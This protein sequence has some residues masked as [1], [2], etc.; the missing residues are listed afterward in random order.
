[1]PDD[2]VD[3]LYIKLNTEEKQPGDLRIILKP[4]KQNWT[5]QIRR[6]SDV[7][8]KLIQKISVKS[9]STNPN[10]VG[11]RSAVVRDLKNLK[12]PEEVV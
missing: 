1:M 8:E 9:A 10:M 6:T 11:A 2:N 7:Q 4:R 5:S 3:N 12:A